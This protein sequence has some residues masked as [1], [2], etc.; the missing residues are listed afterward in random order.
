MK[1]I[2]DL[3]FEWRQTEWL[4]S[5]VECRPTDKIHCLARRLGA[6]CVVAE[7]AIEGHGYWESRSYTTSASASAE[8]ERFVRMY[9]AAEG[10][11]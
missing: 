9:L 4:D 3:K 2:T 6:S 8:C 1:D 7:V 11:K 5:G 10:G